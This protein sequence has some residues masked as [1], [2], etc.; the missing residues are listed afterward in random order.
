MG[1]GL[2][3][4]KTPWFLGGFGGSDIVSLMRTG[5]FLQ[6]CVFAS[7]PHFDLLLLHQ[8][9]WKLVALGICCCLGVV[10]TG[11]SLAVLSRLGTDQAA[12]SERPAR[13]FWA[14]V[15]GV[16]AGRLGFKAEGLQLLGIA[17]GLLDMKR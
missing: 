17:K 4:P 1:F 5:L 11:A 2:R 3:G 8:V 6:G 10:A 7:D 15:V 12:R 14:L 16:G 9:S 13:R